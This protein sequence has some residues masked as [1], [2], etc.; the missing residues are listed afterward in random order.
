MSCRQIEVS[1]DCGG[2][3]VSSPH[4]DDGRDGPIDEGE[5]ALIRALSSCVLLHAVDRLDHP[6]DGGSV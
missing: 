3:S 2:N 1:E 5:Q 4:P 6:V